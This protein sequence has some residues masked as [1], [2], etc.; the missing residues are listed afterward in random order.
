MGCMIKLA[1]RPIVTYYALVICNHAPTHTLRGGLGMAVEM[2]RALTKDLPRQ[3]EGNI[4]ALL[5][6]G[7]KGREMKR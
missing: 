7:K 5:Y 6:I 2:S 3:C 4:R 1:V